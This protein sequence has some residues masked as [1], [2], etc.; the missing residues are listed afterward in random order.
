QVSGPL[1]AGLADAVVDVGLHSRY[2]FIEGQ[3][4]DENLRETVTHGVE[5]RGVEAPRLQAVG[6]R[7]EHRDL[8]GEHA[9]RGGGGGGVGIEVDAVGGQTQM[10]GDEQRA[11]VEL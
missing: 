2:R 5:E 1:L 4:A 11:A 10:S 6:E 8:A 7:V 3:F 9:Q